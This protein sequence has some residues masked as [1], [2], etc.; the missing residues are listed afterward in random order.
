[1]TIFLYKTK[2][3]LF[4]IKRNKYPICVFIKLKKRYFEKPLN[5]NNKS[6]RIEKG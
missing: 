1:M 4:K 5:S 2:I 6:V 3:N